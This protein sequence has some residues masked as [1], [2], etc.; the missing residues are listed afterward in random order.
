MSSA[1]GSTEAKVAPLSVLDEFY[2]HLDRPDEPFSVQ[3][4]A[5]MEGPVDPGRLA[6]AVRAATRRHPLARARLRASRGTDVRYHWELADE[7]TEVPLDVADCA[8][9]GALA[10][11]RERALG[12]SPSLDRAPPF[13]LTLARHPAGDALMLNLNHA[14]GDGISAVRLMASILRA[15][16]GHADPT[17]PVDPLAVRDIGAL[18]GSTSLRTRL[19]RV[20]ALLEQAVRPTPPARI[21]P[22][23]G[24]PHRR[25]YGFELIALDAAERA[26]IEALRTEGATV[27]DVL[28]GALAATVHRWNR[29]RYVDGAR[30][31]IMMPVNLRP[32]G[33]RFDVVG[34]FASYVAV[35]VGADEARDVR[36]AVAAAAA[37][38]GRIKRDGTAGVL[39]DLVGLPTATLPTAV[40]QRFQRLITMTG[41]HFVATTVLSNLGR[42]APLPNLG[43]EAGSVREVWFSPPGRMP[44]GV[45]LGAAGWGDRLLLTVRYR[46]ALL[47]APGAAAFAALL[48][49][50]LT[51]PPPPT[52][53]ATAAPRS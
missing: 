52:T 23:G 3:L 48:R 12:V 46:H 47:D 53:P 18:V 50:T 10:A 43:D 5:R 14:A 45:S 11:A 21:A 17:P 41:D 49:E 34:N 16:A 35:H 32:A 27:N 1:A 24:D 2:L 30:I 8:D 9:D 19:A 39:V 7:L 36:A 33:W 4:E 28:L 22:S 51:S 6:D 38:T 26:G 15:F 20:P 37:R 25:G 40:K 44:L 42:L 29:R 31:A 13:T